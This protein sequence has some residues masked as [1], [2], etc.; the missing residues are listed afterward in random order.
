VQEYKLKNLISASFF[1]KKHYQEAYT[2][3]PLQRK[4]YRKE[5]TLFVDQGIQTG[6][7]QLQHNP[8]PKVKPA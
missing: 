8:K 7:P 2:N 6:S 1:F 5:R 4:R 3:T